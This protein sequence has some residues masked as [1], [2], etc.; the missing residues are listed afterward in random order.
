MSTDYAERAKAAQA[1]NEALEAYVAGI[2]TDKIPV[3][4][5]ELNRAYFLLYDL[6]RKALIS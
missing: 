1:I 5:A 3:L 4:R 6:D 2:G